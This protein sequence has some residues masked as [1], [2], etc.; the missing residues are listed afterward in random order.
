MDDSQSIKSETPPKTVGLRVLGRI[1]LDQYIKNTLKP[2]DSLSRFKI[3][4][5]KVSFFGKDP[6]SIDFGDAASL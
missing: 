5:M 1:D 2:V 4:Q 3:L 6:I